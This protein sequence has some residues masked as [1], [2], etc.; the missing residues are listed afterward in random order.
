M[1]GLAKFEVEVLRHMSEGKTDRDIALEM[2]YAFES[3]TRMRHR[4]YK[5]L[6]AKNG[7]H[8]VALSLRKGI[9]Q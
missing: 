6:G 8:A 7:P 9:I 4:I 3:L 5:K 1:M 2:S